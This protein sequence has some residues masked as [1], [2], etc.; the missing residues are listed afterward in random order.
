MNIWSR[1]AIFFTLHWTNGEW[2]GSERAGLVHQLGFLRQPW[3]C[4]TLTA[5]GPAGHSRPRGTQSPAGASWC[6]FLTSQHPW[7]FAR[8]LRKGHLQRCP[9]STAPSASSGGAQ[10][11]GA[12]LA[13]HMNLGKY[14]FCVMITESAALEETFRT[15]QSHRHLPKPHPQ[16]PD[17]S[18]TLAETPAPDHSTHRCQTTPNSFFFVVFYG[19]NFSSQC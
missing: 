8:S 15:I 2:T 1:C 13:S 14:C 3:P 10:H 16:V 17:T 12:V 6:Q 7:G 11:N 5:P 18:W 4:R 9:I 19:H